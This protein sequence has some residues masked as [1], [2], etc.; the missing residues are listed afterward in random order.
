MYY[1]DII[2]CVKALFGDPKFAPYL[3]FAPEKHYVDEKKTKR[4]YHDM[5]TGKWWW[6]TQVRLC[7]TRLSNM[8]IYVDQIRKLLRPQHLA[9]RSSL[10]FSPVIKHSSPYF[11][12]RVPTLSTSPLETSQKKSD[13]SLPTGLISFLVIFQPR[14]LRIFPI[15]QGAVAY[16]PISTMH[17]YQKSSNLSKP[18]VPRG[19]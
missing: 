15:S 12:T 1:R 7:I 2:A 9:Q 18:L 13:E 19:S 4:M 5:L 14:A 16:S 8:V 17:A 6:A 10:S 11:V 3:V